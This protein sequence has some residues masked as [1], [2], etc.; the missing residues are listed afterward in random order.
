MLKPIRYNIYTTSQVF[1]LD[2]QDGPC[3]L[4]QND[5]DGT[6]GAIQDSHIAD[7][8]WNNPGI[9]DLKWK[10]IRTTEEW[11]PIFHLVDGQEAA[12]LACMD[13]VPYEGDGIGLWIVPKGY[14]R[15]QSE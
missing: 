7:E 8:W 6:S 3:L 5:S 9:S 10:Y 15:K 2:L 11:I 13:I 14:P 1:T 12:F 4:Y